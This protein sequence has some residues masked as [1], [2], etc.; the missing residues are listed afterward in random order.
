[1]PVHVLLG[2]QRVLQRHRLHLLLLNVLTEAR[3]L[4]ALASL[5]AQDLLLVRHRRPASEHARVYLLLW[6]RHQVLQFVA[7]LLGL[8][9]ADVVVL[10][11]IAEVR[12]ADACALPRVQGAVE[13]VHFG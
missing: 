3:A 5:V 7:Q 11:V 4:Q 13:A 6:R 2:Q 12:V 10:V 9:G 1:M 8:P